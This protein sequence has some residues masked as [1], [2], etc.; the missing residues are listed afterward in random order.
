M[1][2]F[3]NSAIKNENEYIAELGDR[4]SE[5]EKMIDW[6]QFNPI[7][8]ELYLNN[9]EKGGCPNL[10]EVP[11]IKMLCHSAMARTLRSGT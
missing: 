11:M 5:V 4:L 9:T 6:E 7:I 3:T 10:D 1:S 8:K 2:T